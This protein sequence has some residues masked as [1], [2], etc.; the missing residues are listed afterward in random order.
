MALT[1]RH[2]DHPYMGCCED[3]SEVY[4]KLSNLAYRALEKGQL[5]FSMT[6]TQKGERK[7]E[8]L[9][10]RVVASIGEN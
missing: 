4:I 10:W 6:L 5:Y 9:V 1:A 8:M 3:F 2:E 7:L